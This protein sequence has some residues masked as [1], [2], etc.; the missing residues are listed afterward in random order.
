MKIL[1]IYKNYFPIIGGIEN[2]IKMLAEA[3]AATGFDVTVLATSPVLKT[4]VENINAVKVIKAASL[5][6]VSRTPL[7]LSLLKWV[8]E[9]SPDITHLHFPYPVGE[10]ANY[11]FGKSKH[12]IITYH[13]DI[14]KQQFILKLY[15]PL[16]LRVLEKADRIIATSPRYIET[17]PFLSRVRDKCTVIPLGTDLNRFRTPDK[18][19]SDEIRGKYAGRHIL[20]FVGRLRYF[21][22]L[23]YLVEAMKSIDAILLIAGTGPEEQALKS[24]V[25]GD[26]LEE[27]VIFLGDVPDPD[28]PAY[29]DACDVFVL[30]S[31]HRSEAFG[32]VLLEA[33]AAGKAV[34]S[35]ELGT[36]TSFINLHDHTGFV[37]PPREP[38]AM[39]DSINRLLSDEMLREKFGNNARKRAEEFSQERITAMVTDL[40][41]EV[42]LG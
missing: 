41:K 12:T 16:L 2:Y 6:T 19:R 9:L 28:L 39:A 5:S 18:F 15:R 33:L 1:H 35:T 21:K 14:V 4:T 37:V 40:Y 25:Q 32:T 10:F 11:F 36:G 34:I 24:Q 13:S 29:Y 26:R 27:K 38:R 7:S 23:R 3:Q 31:S 20:L 22:G 17:S 42:S 30:P 8:H